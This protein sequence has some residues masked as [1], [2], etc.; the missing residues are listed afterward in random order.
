[1]PQENDILMP[2]YFS[3]CFKKE[4]RMSFRESADQQ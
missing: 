2:K 3:L 1:M 4:Y